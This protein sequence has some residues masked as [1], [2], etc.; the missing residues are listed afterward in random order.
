MEVVLPMPEKPLGNF[1]RY[2]GLVRAVSENGTEADIYLGAYHIANSGGGTS[3][4]E[5]CLNLKANLPT[6][7]YLQNTK[8]A[9]TK[10]WP[11]IRGIEFATPNMPE[12]GNPDNFQPGSILLV[13][14]GEAVATGYQCFKELGLD[15]SEKDISLIGGFGI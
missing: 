13:R 2:C 5:A 8:D 6:D 12:G 15:L 1:S 3:Y 14:G 7:G 4:M 10:L 9:L 11:L